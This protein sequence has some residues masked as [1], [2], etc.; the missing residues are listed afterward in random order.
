LAGFPVDSTPFEQWMVVQRESLHLQTLEVLN[1]LAEGHEERG[2]YE[3]AL[4]YARRQIELELWQEGA[5]CAAHTWRT[6]SPTARSW[7]H[8][9]STARPDGG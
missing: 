8:T 9:R 6:C 2:K 4:R 1:V 5:T 3:Q 7:L